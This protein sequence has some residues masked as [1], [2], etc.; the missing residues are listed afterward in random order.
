MIDIK[1]KPDSDK[2]I[3]ALINEEQET[4]EKNETWFLTRAPAPPRN[5]S[6]LRGKWVFKRK[7]TRNNKVVRLKRDWLQLVVT[8]DYSYIM[9]MHN[10][11]YTIQSVL[12]IDKYLLFFFNQ[13]LRRSTKFRKKHQ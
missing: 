3:Q 5:Q 1:G 12:H 8:N 2:W 6:I 10:I 9:L 7:C 11:R 4:D 13:N